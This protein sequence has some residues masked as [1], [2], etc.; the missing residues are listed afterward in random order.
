MLHK[1]KQLYMQGLARYFRVESTKNKH[2]YIDKKKKLRLTG[3]LAI[4][5]STMIN[6][7]RDIPKATKAP[8]V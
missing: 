7:I 2:T 1:C 5:P 4:Q 6:T 3:S 8:I